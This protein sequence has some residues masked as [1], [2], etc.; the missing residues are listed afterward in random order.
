VPIARFIGA[1]ALSAAFVVLPA[2]ASFIW[3]EINAGSVPATAEFIHG[4]GALTQINGNLDFDL[5]TL[6][7]GVDLYI[8]QI[9]D[10]A[11]FSAQSEDGPGNVSDPALYLFNA[12]GIGVYMNNDNSGS[13]FQATLPPGNPL[14]PLTNGLYYLAVAWGFSDALSF[15]SIF[16][17]DQFLDTTGVYGPTGPGGSDPLA[18]WNTSSAPGNFDLPAH[19][20]IDLVSAAPE[21]A[22]LSLLIAAVTGLML[23]RRVAS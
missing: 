3:N 20:T 14:G 7:W 6:T 13:D 2:R 15:D 9:T 18:G 21:P 8:I 1:L 12:A 5:N 19:Y 4:Q 16:S 11:T 22:T 23:R 17:L 10:A